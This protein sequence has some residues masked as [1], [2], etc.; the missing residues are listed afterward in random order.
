[1]PVDKVY[2]GLFETGLA[3]SSSIVQLL[4]IYS[5]EF[6]QALHEALI[7]QEELLAYIDSK[8]IAKA[9]VRSAIS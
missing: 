4:T 3:F 1:M 9:Q 5:C 7:R 6:P 8:E 2:L